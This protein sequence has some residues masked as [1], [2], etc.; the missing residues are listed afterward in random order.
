[1]GCRAPD[2]WEGLPTRW[3]ALFPNAAL[4]LFGCRTVFQNALDLDAADGRLGSFL[5]LL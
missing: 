4:V 3:L 5:D 1:M 2:R